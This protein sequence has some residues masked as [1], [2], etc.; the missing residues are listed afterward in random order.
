[1]LNKENC[2]VLY[3]NSYLK[4]VSNLKQEGKVVVM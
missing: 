4:L 3:S 1:M 2:I